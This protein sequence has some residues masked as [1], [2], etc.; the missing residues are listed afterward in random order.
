MSDTYSVGMA[1]VI[2]L[3]FGFLFAI[4]VLEAYCDFKGWPTISNQ[5]AHWSQRNRWLS[6]A[7]VA[8]LFILLAH[9]VLNPLHP[10]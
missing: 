10:T 6:G 7:I 1:A 5:V 4:S 3:I 2:W 8:A 9:F